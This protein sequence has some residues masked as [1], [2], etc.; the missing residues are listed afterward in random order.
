MYETIGGEDKV[1][2]VI[3][4]LYDKLFDDPIAGFLFDGKDK[5]RIV[6]QQVAFTC[7]FLG[8]PQIYE[9]K[10]MPDAHARLPLLPGHFDRRHVLLA[11]TLEEK[12]VPGDVQRV[13]LRID[14]ALRTSVLA[15]GEDAR[16]KTR[17]P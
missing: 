11:R 15:T 14:E 5:A 7:H 4:S 13:W 16:D 8:G 12:N 6:L 1:R 2:A 10:S 17:A 3:Q 9:G